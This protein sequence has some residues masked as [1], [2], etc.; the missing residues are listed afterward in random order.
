[1]GQGAAS[2]R[3]VGVNMDDADP[4]T[5]RRSSRKAWEARENSIQP[6]CKHKNRQN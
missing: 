4:L 3:S 5:V 2:T 6:N 1:L